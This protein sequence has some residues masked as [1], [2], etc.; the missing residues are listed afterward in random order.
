MSIINAIILGLVQG[1]TEFLPISSSGHLV[2]ASSLLG[3]GNAF[4]FDVLLNFGSLL[5]L[6]IYYRQRIWSIIQRFFS[7]NEWPLVAKVI[8]A[9]IPGV[10]LGLTLSNE[11][12]KLNGMIW[13]V[14]IAQIVIG[15]PMIVIG[16]ANK[17]ADDREIEESVGWR[18]SLKTG[19]AQASALI[20]GV[21]R[22]GI[23]ILA[24]LRGN[25][26]AERAAE[27]SFL[28]AIPI[29][30][31]ASLKTLISS[32]GMNFIKNNLAAFTIGNIIC[33]ISGMLAINFLIKLIGKRGLKDFGWYRVILAVVLIFM[34]L[35]G[36][37]K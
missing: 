1:I 19:I 30:A 37:I 7:G 32:D 8:V 9:T 33:F 23:T 28:L 11:V 18:L 21:S 20:P 31:G 26:S 29:I 14:I 12:E 25:L 2:I 35:I 24:G 4:T 13:V 5:A 6:I 16:K 3:I 10:A 34:A 15:I 17:N 36:I 22:S 27:F